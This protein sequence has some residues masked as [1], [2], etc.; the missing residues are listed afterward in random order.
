MLEKERRRKR[1]VTNV[2][3]KP[4]EDQFVNIVKCLESNQPNM[5][6]NKTAANF[7]EELNQSNENSDKI[8]RYLTHKGKIKRVLKKSGSKEVRGQRIRSMDRQLI[9]E[10]TLLCLFKKRN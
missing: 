3:T 4:A 7:A 1:P 8:E 2:K 5:N 10:V 6:S 9:N